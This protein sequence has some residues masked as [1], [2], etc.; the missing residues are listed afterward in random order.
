MIAYLQGKIIFRR[1]N[2]LILNTGQ[3][4]YKVFLSEN[5]LNKISSNRQELQLFTSLH[6]KEEG[7]ELYGFLTFKELELFETLKEISGI[8]PKTALGLASL[9]SLEKL[10]GAIEKGELLKE[11]KGIGRKKAQK[12]LL[13]LTGK[14]KDI[15]KPKEILEKDEVLEALISLGFSSH[16]ARLALSQVP[17]EIKDSEKRIKEALK[18]LNQS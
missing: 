9:G 6:F 14:I 8:G 4:G 2:F 1:K 5:A 12:I 7:A 11:I 15:E 13:E 3:I 16:K 17:R 10:K 18:W